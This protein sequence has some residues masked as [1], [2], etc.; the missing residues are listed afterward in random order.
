MM[1]VCASMNPGSSVASPRSIDARAGGNGHRSLPADGDDLVVRDHDDAVRDRRG[2]GAVD[3]SR[4][5]EHDRAGT[6]RFLC[7]RDSCGRDEGGR[8]GDR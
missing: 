4:G 7:V 3:D 6:L 8:Q 5:A 1:C 2:A